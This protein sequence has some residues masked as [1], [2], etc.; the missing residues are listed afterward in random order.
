MIIK[1]PTIA[2]I[3]K[4]KQPQPR[5]RSRFPKSKGI[6]QYDEPLTSKT[7]ANSHIYT[8]LLQIQSTLI[9]SYFM[10]TFNVYFE[11][12]PPSIT[13]LY[14]LIHR[15]PHLLSFLK[16]LAIYIVHLPA[17]YIIYFAIL[18]LLIHVKTFQIY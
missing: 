14:R 8:Y 1:P 11:R 13:I 2:P 3:T 15:F 9:I 17:F 10:Y 18:H 6:H 12:T 16:S 4:V 7:S 5:R